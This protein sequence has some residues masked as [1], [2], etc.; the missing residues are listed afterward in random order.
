MFEAVGRGQDVSPEHVFAYAALRPA[1]R[2]DDGWWLTGR[3]DSEGNA[4]EAERLVERCAEIELDGLTFSLTHVWRGE[5]VL[6]VA[7]G[8]DPRVTDSDAFFR[9]RHPVLRPQPVVAE[10]ERTARAAERWTR[11]VSKERK[12]SGS[13]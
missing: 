3:P 11:E 12:A 7:G 5:A 10:A 13:T 4:A 6:R 2:R 1:E 8:A 9:D